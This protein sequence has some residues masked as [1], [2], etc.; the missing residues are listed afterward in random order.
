MP[1]KYFKYYWAQT[2]EVS[3]E[4]L[5]AGQEAFNF[6]ERDLGLIGK[7]IFMLYIS[8]L[9]FGPLV[10]VTEGPIYGKAI[11]P[12][13]YVRAPDLTVRGVYGATG[14]E[15]RHLWQQLHFPE[16]AGGFTEQ[17]RFER[18]S[19]CDAY[20]RFVLKNLRRDLL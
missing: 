11:W 5:I 7:H 1:I 8:R 13:A 18:E 12:C 16:P 10:L 9:N 14:H 17:E 20:G 3:E 2:F 19:D 15:I 6:A 4:K